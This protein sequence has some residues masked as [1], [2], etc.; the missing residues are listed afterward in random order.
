MYASFSQASTSRVSHLVVGYIL[1]YTLLHIYLN[2]IKKWSFHKSDSYYQTNR[3]LGLKNR[4]K[5]KIK[6]INKKIFIIQ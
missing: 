4:A 6:I 3:K 5:C 2:T 1:D